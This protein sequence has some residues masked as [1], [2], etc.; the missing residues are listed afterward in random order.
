M[1]QLL[2]NKL[3]E[4]DITY[5]PIKNQEHLKLVYDLFVNNIYPEEIPDDGT[6]YRYI[7]LYHGENGNITEKIRYLLLGISKNH[8]YSMYSLGNYYREQK[9]IENMFKYCLMAIEHGDSN[10]MNNLGWYYYEQKDT[11][12]MFKY[13]LMAIEH[14]DSNAMNNLGWYYYEQKDTEN[15]FKYYLMTIEHGESNAM[16]NLG[17][18]Y[19]KQK[20]TENMLKYFLMACK[21]NNRTAIENI[22]KHFRNNSYGKYAHD[23]KDFLDEDN[24]IKYSRFFEI[25]LHEDLSDCVICF[26]TD[27]QPVVMPQCKCTKTQSICI[28]CYYNISLCPVCK[29]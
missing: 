12:N 3:K 26:D 16:N 17:L 4:L 13:Y 24:K 2:Q 19:Y 18:Y 6:V 21:K 5:E 8:A 9:D 10:A 27:I 20:D 25:K 11:E 15:M 28:D 22:N 1:E 14:G 23:F 7:G 29:T